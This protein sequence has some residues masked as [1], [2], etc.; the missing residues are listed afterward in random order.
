MNM[1]T[2]GTSSPPKLVSSL[3]LLSQWAIRYIQPLRAREKTSSD[4]L[5]FHSAVSSPPSSEQSWQGERSNVERSGSIRSQSERAHENKE[6]DVETLTNSEEDLR[7]PRRK[8]GSNE[9]EELVPLMR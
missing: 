6:D 3:Q 5:S 2:R 8:G 1:M 7:I 9:K 4:S